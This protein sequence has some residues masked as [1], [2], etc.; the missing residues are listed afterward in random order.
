MK[1]KFLI[2]LLAG[3]GL[4]CACKGKG[5][6]EYDVVNN[7]TSSA[8]ADSTKADSIAFVGSKLIK[9]AGMRFKVKSVQQTSEHIAAL[10]SSF[11]GM[12]MHHEM[13]SIADRS[14]D[15]R[16]SNDSLIRVTAFSTTADLTIKIPSAKLEDFM[17][18]V[19]RMGIYVN[20]RSMDITDKSLE[21]LSAQLKLKSRNELI[22]QQKKGRIVIKDPAKVLNLK[23]DMIDQ[24]INNREIDAAVKF[25][26]VSLSFYESNTINREVIANDDPSAYNLPFSKRVGSALENGW[27]LFVDLIVGVTN[28]WVFIMAGLLVW[29]I[30]VRYKS[31]KQVVL[32]K[33]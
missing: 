13:G 12:I 29:F 6:A 11:C 2:P 1:T 31:K 30:I 8:A 32:A 27:A 9:T 28:L 20:S 26:V 23:D 17:N 5:K 10:T 16:L 19:S 14:L 24:Q 15:N 33:G 7:S 4:L 21:Y 22:S 25:S 3:V 18:Q